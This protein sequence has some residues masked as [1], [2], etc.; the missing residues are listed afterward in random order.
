VRAV[1]GRHDGHVEKFIDD[2]V[3]AVFGTL[4]V[5]EDDGPGAKIAPSLSATG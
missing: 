2:A 4:V 1:V 3:I 5:R